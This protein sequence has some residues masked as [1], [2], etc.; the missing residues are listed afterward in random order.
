MFELFLLVCL[1]LMI[2]AS[3]MFSYRM[4]DDS[5]T[6][7]LDIEKG[8]CIYCGHKNVRKPKCQGFWTTLDCENCNRISK[9]HVCKEE[10]SKKY[11]NL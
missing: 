4:Y 9:V 10:L 5:S 3:W 6:M 8:V 1:C 11:Q 7:F 2:P